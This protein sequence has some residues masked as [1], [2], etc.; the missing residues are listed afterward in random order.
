M[1]RYA[2]GSRRI[3]QPPTTPL[4]SPPFPHRFNA[5]VL[6]L[7]KA[8]VGVVAVVLAIF[9]VCL[10]HGAL[11]YAPVLG[12]TDVSVLATGDIE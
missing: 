9:T 7:H 2:C 11:F 4:Q 3:A 10:R 8:V 1:A 5:L 12:S 6:I